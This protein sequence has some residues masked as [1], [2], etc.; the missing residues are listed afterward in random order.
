VSEL[1]AIVAHEIGHYKNGHITQ[2]IAVQVAYL[3]GVFFCMSLVLGESGLFDAFYVSNESTYAGLVFFGLLFTPV[4]MLLSFFVNVLSRKNEFE[5][6]GFA[7]KT[8][9]QAESLISALKKLSTD[10]LS[11]L[12][13][14]PLHVLLNYSHP[15]VLERIN[16]LRRGIAA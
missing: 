9:D 6:D 3:G 13:P 10:S 7:A 16:A 2:G 15:P 5:A 4:D 8:S 11:N 12:T 14:H 1:V